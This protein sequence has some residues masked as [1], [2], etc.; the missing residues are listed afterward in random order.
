MTKNKKQYIFHLNR[1]LTEFS[2]K[3]CF[4]R[5]NGEMKIISISILY[6]EEYRRINYI[7]KTYV[8]KFK[9]NQNFAF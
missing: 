9:K 6:I 5:I 8:G 2:L 3:F 1:K 4:K 7:K